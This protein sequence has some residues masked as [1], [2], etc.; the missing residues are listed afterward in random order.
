[1]RSVWYALPL[2]TAGSLSAQQIPPLPD[3]SAWGVHVLALARAPDSSIW[4]GTYGQGIYVLRPGATQWEHLTASRDT[5][6]HS[7]SFDFVHAFAFGPKGEIWYGTV[8]NGWGLST[9][10]GKPW[11]NWDGGELGKEWL[12]VAPNGIVTRGDTTYI[13][14][15]DGINLT[16]DNGASWAEITDSA[17]ATT[18]KNVWGRIPGQYVTSIE[19][20]DLQSIPEF[21]RDRVP[22]EWK[23]G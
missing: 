8:G 2:L 12:Y 21:A 7:I 4:A 17:G 16:W 9:D 1:M 6:V 10:G 15:A 23:D 14:T 5:A 19:V 18:A 11:R 22:P 20:N 13:A 3:S